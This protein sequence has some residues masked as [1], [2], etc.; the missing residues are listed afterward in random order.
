MV[1]TICNASGMN[2]Y[3]IELSELAHIIRVIA[4]CLTSFEF[5]KQIGDNV[6]Y[7]AVNNS[8]QTLTIMFTD[9]L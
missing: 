1:I 6:I 9:N 3:N 5:Y 8:G 7:D 2:T 4:N